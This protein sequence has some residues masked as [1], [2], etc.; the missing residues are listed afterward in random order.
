MSNGPLLD[1]SLTGAL[2]IMV[3]EALA[4]AG[5][6]INATG[7]GDVRLLTFYVVLALGISFLCSILEAVVLSVTQTWVAVERNNGSKTGEL[8]SALKEDDAV[9]PLTAI[10]T[11]NT[12]SHTMG[13]AGVGSQVQLIYGDGALTLASILLTLAMLLLSEIVPKTIGAAYWKQLARP[14]GSLLRIV[15]WSMTILIVPIQILKRVLPKGELNL[16]SRDDVAALA[17]L[18]EE[19]GVLN[20]DEEAIIHN[21][22]R[23]RDILVKDVMTPR[24]VMQTVNADATV[25]E[26]TE[27]M[28]V[29]RFS[30]M[31]VLG[32]GSDDVLGLVLRSRILRASSNDEHDATMDDLM[33]PITRI[34]FEQSVEEALDHFLE[35][36]QHFALVTNEFGGTE[37]AVTLEDV[38]ETLIG[39]EIVD[40]LDEVEDMREYAREQAALSSE[41]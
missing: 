5:P 13:A 29:L 17:D 33:Q 36:K 3:L 9:G 39:E 37:G 20:E 14:C 40:E 2:H 25:L 23:L 22:L 35:S 19:R 6:A 27:S 21:L 18:G 32:A 8:W 7:T 1:T 31:P 4:A 41:E 34:G 16:V 24:T 10:L 15:V 12:I 38:F 26:V 30:R 28:P 11:L